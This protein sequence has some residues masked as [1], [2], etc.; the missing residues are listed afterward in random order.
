[1]DYGIGIDL[2]ATNVKGIAVTRSGRVMAEV[3]VPTG[4]ADHPRWVDRVCQAVRRLRREAGG[5]PAWA[6]LAAP[7]LP[8]RDGW[9]IGCMPGRL[10]GLEGL[11][12]SDFL[13]LGC[14]VPVL[15]DAQAALLGEVWLG[16]ARG[17][18]DAILLTL[19]TGVGGA[20]R[21]DGRL[22]RGHIGRAGHLG[23]ISLDPAG[24]LDVANTPGSLEDAIG[25]CTVLKRSGGR[26]GSTRE[27]VAAVRLGDAEA[28]GIW[29]TSI[30]AL[31]AGVAGLVNVLD[32]EV[33]VVGGGISDAGP[34]LFRPLRQ[35]LDRFEW[36][37][38]GARV[39][40]VRARLGGRAGAYGAARH[41]LDCAELAG[42]GPL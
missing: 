22:L 31:A 2:G 40:V 38:G 33:V 28:R 35:A 20:A 15:N 8:A 18:E 16:A 10:P 17:S 7:G 37:P 42:G 4:G 29:Q 5:G 34:L 39:R 14:P 21:V 25:D 23:H 41:G 1:M 12:W 36:R 30:R 32:P 6:G 11:V 26:F 24:T 9:S 13:K 3:L 19:G 27:L